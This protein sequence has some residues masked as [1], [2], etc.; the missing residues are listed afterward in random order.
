MKHLCIYHKNCADGFGAALVVKHWLD[1]QGIASE[2]QEFL[3][4]Q[5]GDEAPDVTGKAV[6]VVDFSYS[7]EILESINE[8]AKSLIVIDHHKTAQQDLEGLAFC[9]FD[10]G[11]SGAMLAW[12]YFFPQDWDRF[13]FP[14]EGVIHEQPIPLLIHYIQDRD[15]WKWELLKSK[16]VSAALQT[17][18]MTFE[19]WTPYLDD[20]NID[21]LTVQGEAILAYQQRQIDKVVNAKLNMITLCGHEVPCVNTTTLISEIGNELSKRHPFAVMYFDTE[22]KRVYSLRSAK[23][24]VDVSEIAKRFGG[25]GHFNAAGFAVP[26][27]ELL[28]SATN[29]FGWKLEELLDQAADE[30]ELKN[31]ALKQLH[32]SKPRLRISRNNESIIAELRQ[33]SKCQ[34]ATLAILDELGPNQGPGGTPRV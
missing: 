8:A 15:L 7:R 19:A 24:G 1:G 13:I 30:V 31:E 14:P 21:D 27:A 32:R 33:A 5:Y 12:R 20:N 28:M 4:A 10:M 3:A 11:R 34:R 18:P 9:L 17:L 22:D 16:E 29:P 23:D 6:Y 2:N 25:G 26:N